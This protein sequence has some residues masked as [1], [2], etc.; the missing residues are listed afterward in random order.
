M[1]SVAIE[2]AQIVAGDTL[3]IIKEIHKARARSLTFVW[4]GVYVCVCVCVSV[5]VRTCVRV[6]VWVSVS[7]CLCCAFFRAEIRRLPIVRN[8]L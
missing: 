4:C 5:C 8:E 3:P 7:V 1:L 6:C 2:S